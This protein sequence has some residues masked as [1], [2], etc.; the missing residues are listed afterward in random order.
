MTGVS[1]TANLDLVASLGADVVI[2]YR[3]QDF[4][5]GSARYDVVFDA[6]GRT[7][8]KKAARVLAE[9]G[10]FA[11]TQTRRREQVDDLIAVRDMVASGAV[12]AVIDRSYS[13]DRIREAHR[14]VEQGHKRGNVVVLVA[15]A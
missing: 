7:T 3:E 13:L 5:E 11:T 8:A 15:R 12:R 4:T 1:S 6:A 9:H 10:R 2:D 14:Y